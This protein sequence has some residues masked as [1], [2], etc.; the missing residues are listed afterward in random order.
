MDTAE[1]RTAQ[2]KLSGP[3]AP[4]AGNLPIGRAEESTGLLPPRIRDGRTRGRA[5]TAA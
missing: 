3:D 5:E 1:N 2:T 4:M